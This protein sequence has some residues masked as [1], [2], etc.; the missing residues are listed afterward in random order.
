MTILIAGTRGGR[1]LKVFC[2]KCK[3]VRNPHACVTSD[4]G[5]AWAVT[6]EPPNRCFIPYSKEIFKMNI[7]G[8]LQRRQLLKIKL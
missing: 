5:P 2:E 3:R 8:S 4:E 6:C 1:E 7:G